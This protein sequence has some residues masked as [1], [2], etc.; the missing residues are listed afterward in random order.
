GGERGFG[1]VLDVVV[2]GGHR[3]VF[4]HQER[5]G[6]RRLVVDRDAHVAERADDAVDSFGID[7][8]VGQMVVDFAVGQVAAVF[9]ELDELL[10]AVAAG[11]VLFGRNGAAR[12]QV[13]GIGLAPLAAALGR[14]EI[15]Q[16]FAFAV[17]RIVEGVVVVVG[18]LGRAARTAPA[19]RT[20]TTAD[21]V[22]QL[23][24]G[25]LGACGLDLFRL[26]G[27]RGRLRCLLGGRFRGRF[28]R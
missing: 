10:E 8:V 22:G 16:H 23:V 13:L 18:V 15:G 21:Q 28:C 3:R 19:G 26:V 12:D 27:G 14:L 7:Q 17:H 1:F 11:F 20:R 2:V 6:I 25:L 9:A 4:A 5:F 24:L